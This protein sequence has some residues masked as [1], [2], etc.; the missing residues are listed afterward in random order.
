MLDM[1]HIRGALPFESSVIGPAKSGLH[2]KLS[3][4]KK[5]ESI[6]LLFFVL[7]VY[8]RLLF[9]SH[10][11]PDGEIVCQVSTKS[12]VHVTLCLTAVLNHSTLIP[13]VCGTVIV[14]NNCVSR[15]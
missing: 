13:L 12:C 2:Y 4:L 9:C 3:F 15:I 7:H 6:M 8:N 10:Y 1:A 11:G 5:V 14:H